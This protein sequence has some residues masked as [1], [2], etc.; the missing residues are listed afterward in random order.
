[1]AISAWDDPRIEGVP[2]GLFDRDQFEIWV[3][4]IQEVIAFERNHG[5]G[6]FEYGTRGLFDPGITDRFGRR[7][8]G[9]AG[10]IVR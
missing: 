10:P 9:V 5:T 2:H 4:R 8:F 7:W 1:M 3:C 6:N